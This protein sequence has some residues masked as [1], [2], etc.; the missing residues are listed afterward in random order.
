MNVLVQGLSVGALTIA[1]LATGFT[2]GGEKLKAKLRSDV[3]KKDKVEVVST[4]ETLN[5]EE[6]EFNCVR[7]FELDEKFVITSQAE[8]V[9]WFKSKMGDHRDCNMPNVDFKKSSLII[10]NVS[11]SG[12]NAP[13]VQKNISVDRGSKSVTFNIDIQQDGYCK[14]LHVIPVFVKVDKIGPDFELEVVQNKTFK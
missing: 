13:D 11:A 3:H 14:M 2:N 5:F 1:M 6:V 10:L 9:K 7:P 4:V 12:C 8:Y